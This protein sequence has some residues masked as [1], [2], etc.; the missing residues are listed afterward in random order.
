[1]SSKRIS[2]TEVLLWLIVILLLLVVASPVA[3]GFKIKSD[4]GLMVDKLSELIQTDIQIINYNRGFFASTALLEIRSPS[5][6]IPIQFKEEIIHGPIYLG[7]INQGKSPFMGALVKGEMLKPAGTEAIMLQLF[8]DQSPYVYQNIIDFVGNMNSESYIPA[9]NTA[10]QD[11]AGQT[12]INFSGMV[13]NTRYQSSS[14]SFT[15]EGRLNTLSLNS[16][17]DINLRGLSISYSGKMG[18]NGIMVGD[19][20]VSLPKL[21]VKSA[22]DQFAINNFTLRSVTTEQGN[23]LNSESMINAREIFLS[24]ERFGPVAFNLSVN[25]LNAP[26]LKKAQ[27]IQQDM[28]AKIQSGVPVEQANA[29]M[30]GEIMG[31]LPDLFKQAE[32]RID[33][34]SI[35]SELGGLQAQLEFSMSGLDQNTPADPMFL[36]NAI[37]IDFALDI[38]K[39][40]M[41]QLVEW[42]LMAAEA[43]VQATGNKASRR[44]ESNVPMQRKVNENI[45]AMMSENWIVFEDEIYSSQISMHQGQMVMN[46]KQVDPVSQ[47][48]S[49]MNSGN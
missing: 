21:E 23:L 30:M 12:K 16:D 7:L 41:Q 9:I 45:R 36:L 4:Y 20:V 3:L 48:M 38:D 24:N 6:P 11:E 18:Q 40:L 33:P 2:L 43:N 47:I 37:N 8:G 39:R 44:M 31:L 19:S 14:Q 27:K 25:G 15:G 22:E 28:Q 17:E 1:M 46:N 42:Q 32:I 34:L 35:E 10:F 5:I 49:Q 29:M 26:A 13:L